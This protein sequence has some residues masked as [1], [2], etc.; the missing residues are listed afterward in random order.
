MESSQGSRRIY[1]SLV[2]KELT[3]ISSVYFDL[4]EEF[5]VDRGVGTTMKKKFCLLLWHGCLH[6]GISQLL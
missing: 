4:M 3:N 2:A 5:M 6:S 1:A